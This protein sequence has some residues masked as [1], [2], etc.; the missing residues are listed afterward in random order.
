MPDSCPSISSDRIRVLIVDDRETVRTGLKL[1]AMAFTD[2]EMIGEAST[3]EGALELARQ[4]EPDV[5][6]M[7]LLGPGP[8]GIQAIRAIHSYCPH[9]QIIALSSLEEDNLIPEA[10]AAGAIRHLP[11]YVSADQLVAAIRTV[12][13]DQIASV[14]IGHLADSNAWSSEGEKSLF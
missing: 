5:V 6:L 12:Y 7:D 13:T 14:E 4:L 3:A 10:L 11:K 2:L 9:I 1:L 8:L